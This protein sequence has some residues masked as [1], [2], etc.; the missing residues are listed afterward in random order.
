MQL[1][2]QA[3][4]TSVICFAFVKLRTCFTGHSHHA[5]LLL[6]ET[7]VILEC[8]EVKKQLKEQIKQVNF[9]L[10]R[11]KFIKMQPYN[12]YIQMLLLSSLL[13][14]HRPY[15]KCTFLCS[16]Y[17][18]DES[19]KWVKVCLLQT[20]DKRIRTKHQK[21]HLYWILIVI[22]PQSFGLLF[23]LQCCFFSCSLEKF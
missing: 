16:C 17:V 21:I 20:H 7:D 12:R 22:L 3:F 8:Q 6:P 11:L 10:Q 15:F 2:F 14:K 13:F 1:N 4:S 18:T 23:C 19:N 5:F 9:P